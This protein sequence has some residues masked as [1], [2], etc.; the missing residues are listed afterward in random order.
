MARALTFSFEAFSVSRR[1][2]ARLWRWLLRVERPRQAVVRWTALGITAVVLA[3]VLVALVTSWPWLLRP[4]LSPGVPAPFSVRAPRSARVIDSVALEQRRS[5]MGN[6]SQVQVVDD[7]ASRAL[8]DELDQ[9]L[10][11]LQQSINS[12]QPRLDP[13]NLSAA[14]RDWL[15][16]LTSAELL[17]WQQAVQK[18]QLRMLSQGVVASVA[19]KPLLMAARLQLESQPPPGQSLGSRLVVRSLQGR[20]NLRGDRVLKQQRIE[21]LVTQ[22]GLPTITV[23][24][25]DLI[26]RQGEAI[27]PQAFDVLDY[28]GLI[29]RRPQP[30]AWMAHFGEALAACGVMVLVMRRWKASLEPRQVLLA[31]AMLL[32]VQGFKL[33]L[34]PQAS[35]LALLVPPTLLLA[36]GLGTAP[37]LAW[38]AVSSL[39]WTHPLEPL[40]QWRLLLAALVAAIAA[41]LAG[42]QRNRAQLL[43]LA[44]LLPAG[45]ALLQALIAQ[46]VSLLWP[47]ELSLLRAPDLMNEAVM[48]GALLMAGL[49]LA[50]LV[51][52]F[53]GLLTRARLME[54]ADLER[55]LL[56]R[57]SIEAPGTFEHTLMILGLAE[58]GARA[59]QADVDLIRT[60]ALYHDV[61][62]LHGP[63]WFIENQEGGDNPH[64]ALDDPMESARIL[65]AHV[66]EGLKLARRHHLPRP[67]ADFIPEHQG[68]LKMGYFLHQARQRLPGVSED[69]FRYRGPI[70]RS[71][72]TGILMLADG[73]EAALRA[74]PPETSE[75][76]ATATVRRIV[77]ARRQDSQLVA[78][79]ISRAELE[80]V[81]RAF[82]RVW[83]RM[84][85]RRIAYP[86]PSGKG[87]SA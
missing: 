74:L 85:H 4:N 44:L 25:G 14:E 53:F 76:Q 58:E 20:T 49:L 13:F 73:C 10:K 18:A 37:G 63:Q 5:V 66:D 3:S 69:R 55:P 39:L 64:D 36:Q 54:L 6:R 21:E 48:V 22:E 84:R 87:F 11:Q 51:E 15:R 80:L 30:L 65:Q 40:F 19:D 35:P 72:E 9:L 50:P 1:P 75:A 16:R 71:R 46:A 62:K 56:R 83:R 7:T 86:L 27:T 45:A 34:G 26:S 33:W 47:G 24:R 82:V 81:I 52:S 78:S 28:F 17:T 61:G 2:L 79:G 43:Q 29:N 68:T 57:L 23:R 31:L 42:R 41:V 12:R 77:E 38:L 67:L 70:P 59:I 32:V 8:Q 60:G